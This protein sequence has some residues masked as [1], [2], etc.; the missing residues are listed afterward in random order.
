MKL[1]L[2]FPN[3][4]VTE[5]WDEKYIVNLF[6]KILFKYFT[7]H[8]HHVL[9][10]VYIILFLFVIFLEYWCLNE[11]HNQALQKK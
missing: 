6:Y 3:T 10:V 9:Q 4:I 11:S 1:Y 7:H 8:I 5:E 2:F